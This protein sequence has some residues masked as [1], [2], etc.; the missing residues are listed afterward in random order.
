VDLENHARDMGVGNT[1]AVR[2]VRAL[3]TVI[4]IAACDGHSHMLSR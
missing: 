4:M 3:H 1:K 2:M